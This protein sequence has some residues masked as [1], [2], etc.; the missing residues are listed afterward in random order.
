MGEKYTQWAEKSPAFISNFKNFKKPDT[1]FSWKRV[2]MKEK[3]GLFALFLI[4]F[5]FDI[6]GEIIQSKT[7]YNYFQ[8][9]MCILT[10]L[11]YLV[12]RYMKR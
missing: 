7:D 6:L 2:L 10:G 5:L 8:I 4:F 1:P 12:L 3:N 9:I 11:S